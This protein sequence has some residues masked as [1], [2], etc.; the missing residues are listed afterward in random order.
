MPSL[1]SKTRELGEL[2]DMYRRTLAA[3][4]ACRAGEFAPQDLIE[5]LFAG[6]TGWRKDVVELSPEEVAAQNTEDSGSVSDASSRRTLL[7]NS[8]LSGLRLT[9]KKNSTTHSRD[10]SRNDSGGSEP[11]S[12]RSTVSGRGSIQQQVNANNT[13][14]RRKSYNPA[15]EVTEFDVRDDLRS[16]RVSAQG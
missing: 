2:Q 4:W 6:G 5:D 12:T 14:K 9:P 3:S 11:Q 7:N 1:T 13:E 15:Q 8:R 10:H 16:W